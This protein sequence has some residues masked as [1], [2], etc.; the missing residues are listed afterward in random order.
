MSATHDG[1]RG[2]PGHLDELNRSLIVGV[3]NVTPDSFSDGGRYD[4]VESAIAHGR[5]LYAG[6]ADVVDV[7]GEST[8]PGAARTAPEIE[9]ER[10][11]PVVGALAEAGV[12]V[13]VD[14]INA[15]TA[16]AAVGAGAVIVNDVSGGLG[17]PG[18]LD[19]V[20]A[21]GTTYVCMHW[22]AYSDQMDDH[23]VYDDVIGEV[24]DE[25]AARL[26]ACV[27][28]GI[29]L[30]RVVIDPGL[31]FAKTPAH[32]WMLLGGLDELAT[33]GRPILVGASRKRFLGELLADSGTG[34]QRAPSGRDVATSTLS[35]LAS[36]RGVWAV[37]VHDVVATHDAIRAAH[38]WST[39]QLDQRDV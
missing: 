14:T 35:A 18:M 19:T 32:N 4:D 10:V 37:R 29:D 13:S 24:R 20:A 25:L 3:L 30:E 1:P 6:G 16:A 28:A 31:G 8:R 11:M 34:A 15:S 39:H 9:R 23:A 2:L 33:L 5:A 22:R 7:G 17:D 12:P 21:L 27:A 38:A 26:D 36:L